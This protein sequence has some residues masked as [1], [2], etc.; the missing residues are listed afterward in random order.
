MDGLLVDC[1]PAV[2][3]LPPTS[4]EKHS[5]S[6]TEHNLTAANGQRLHMPTFARRNARFIFL[7]KPCSHDMV[8]AD[9]VP[10]I[11]GIYFF[12]DGEG[13]R[14]IIDPRRCSLTDR[15]MMEEFPMDN[16]TSSGF[17]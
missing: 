13:K 17:R 11:L 7:G 6:L 1:G 10:P 8:V 15:Y 12:Q 14:C 5:P 3:V 9:V 4:K 16:N 2:S